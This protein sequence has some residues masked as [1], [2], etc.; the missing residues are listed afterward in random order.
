MTRIERRA[1]AKA[2]ADVRRFAHLAKSRAYR[3]ATRKHVAHLIAAGMPEKARIWA[4][5]IK[6]W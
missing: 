5:R 1:A 3:H 2:R 6:E 4:A